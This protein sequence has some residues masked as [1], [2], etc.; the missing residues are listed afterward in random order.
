MHL[1]NSLNIISNCQC[2]LCN[3]IVNLTFS[4]HF[5]KILNRIYFTSYGFPEE[6]ADRIYPSE[7]KKESRIPISSGLICSNNLY[8]SLNRE[9]LCWGRTKPPS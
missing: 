6:K 1:D 8:F 3:L 7:T 4:G 5:Q 2:S 9:V